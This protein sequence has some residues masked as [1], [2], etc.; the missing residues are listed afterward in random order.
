MCHAHQHACDNGKCVDSGLLCDGSNDCG[1][2]SDEVGCEKPTTCDAGMFQCSSGSCVPGSW[3]CDGRI[4]CSDASDEHDKCGQRTC[5]PDMHR[6][7]L[8]QCLDRSLV[9]D[10]HNDCGDRSDELNCS[11]ESTKVNISCAQD[12]FKC[13]ST[14][15]CIPSAAK[16]NGTAECARGE[17]EAD[18]GEMCSIAEFQCRSGRQCIRQEFRCDGERDCSDGSDELSCEEEEKKRH[19]N[20]TQAGV[21]PGQW[22]TSR[23]ACRPNLFDCQDGECVDM[24]RVC[25]N[26]PDCANGRDEGP[27]CATACR[28]ADGRKLCQHKCR[29]TPAG[30]VCSCYDGYRLDSD[31][32]SCSDID[33][34]QQE[35]QPCAQLC[36]NTLGGYQ[37]QCHADFMLRQ[38]R[39]SCKSLESGAT[40]LFSSFNQ[41]RNLSEHPVMLTVAWSAN[42]SRI[43]GFDVDVHREM[44]YFSAEEEDVI[45]QIDLQK[46]HITRALTLP[47]PTKLSLD[48][49]TGNVYVLSGAQ[50][51][52]ACS[53]EARMC[54]RIVL[55]KNHRRLKHLAVDGYHARVFYIAI[56]TEGFGHSSSELHMARLDGS[57]KEMLLQRSDSY[58]TALTTDPH[59][60]LLYYVDLHRR[61]LERISYRAK[62]GPQRR[63]EIML[64][65]S[66][67]LIQ[68]SGLSVFENNA[69]IVN[70]GAK[71]AQQC[72]LYGTRVCR[73]INLNVMNAEDIVV[74]ARSR[75]PQPAAHACLHAHCHGLC[76]QADFGYECMCGH[77][78]VAEGERCPHGSGNEVAIGSSANS[79]ELEQ[80]QQSGSHWLMTLLLLAA[81]LLIGGAGYM[82]YKY[83][84][85]GHTDLNINLHFQNPLATLGGSSS[86]AFLDHERS[87]SG[88]E[89]TTESSQGTG[90][91]TTAS[92]SSSQFG[93]P[94]V[95]QRLLRSRQSSSN[96]PMATEMLLESPRV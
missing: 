28:P 24:S 4:D 66:N 33:E 8:G 34:C 58:M 70:L 22:S 2:N 7:L 41:V 89:F 23:R 51:I 3:E 74:A 10:G 15:K 76:L 63:P 96:D 13:P 6:C 72:A 47:R 78:L 17:D 1:D 36:E 52:Q 93:V 50:E 16:C 71:E 20:Q 25:N 9:C 90:T 67:A 82:Y 92:A 14:K 31:K 5:A 48:W 59:Q 73:N 45:Y 29:A 37:C 84:Q 61:T 38:D 86:K 57:R 21:Q 60:Q 43:S 79:L 12:E 30:A 95:L 11:P 26:F 68:P 40:I 53:F 65:K 46:K 62:S 49:A 56:R 83:R 32:S 75:Q 80:Q 55:A 35:Q 39:V 81:A 19:H 91:N 87:E 88:V 94:T 85:R 18:C 69:Y 64:Q 44:G 54:G 77:R 42:D 27:Q